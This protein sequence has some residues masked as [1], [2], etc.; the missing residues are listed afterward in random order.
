MSFAKRLRTSISSSSKTIEHHT[1]L[2]PFPKQFKAPNFSDILKIRLEEFAGEM[3]S[4]KKSLQSLQEIYAKKDLALA[5]QK[6][7]RVIKHILDNKG[8]IWI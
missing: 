1:N 5:Q 6:E 3:D 7:K 4:V 2:F 8:T